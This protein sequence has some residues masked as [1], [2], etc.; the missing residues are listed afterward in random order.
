MASMAFVA[1]ATGASY[2]AARVRQQQAAAEAEKKKRQPNPLGTNV[3]P[4][5]NGPGIWIGKIGRRDLDYA[6]RKMPQFVD[7]LSHYTA[8][9]GT[10]QATREH[11]RLYGHQKM[12]THIKAPTRFLKRVN[13]DRWHMIDWNLWEVFDNTKQLLVE[14][15]DENEP[16][17]AASFAHKTQ[18]KHILPARGLYQGYH[19]DILGSDRMHMLAGVP[20][21]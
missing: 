1:L 18:K 20:R 4:Q 7:S 21:A 8:F 5:K 13:P 9:A 14:T 11:H 17:L 12:P 6:G 10:R 16:F 3:I 19:K 15:F 2:A